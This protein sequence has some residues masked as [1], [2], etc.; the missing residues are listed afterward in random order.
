M[1]VLSGVYPHGTYD[2]EI[3]FDGATAEFG[4]INDSEDRGVVIIHQEL[5]LV[6]YLSVAE[7][8]FLGNETRNRFGMI[9]WNAAN[10]KAATLLERVGLDEN[11]TTPVGQLGVGKQQLIEIAKRSRRRSSC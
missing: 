10:R 2:G 8:I 7:N 5:A 9:D 11:P 4:S 1:K 6:P 3:V